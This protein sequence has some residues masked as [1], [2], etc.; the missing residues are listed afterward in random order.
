L[1]SQLAN[2]MIEKH[3]SSRSYTELQNNATQMQRFNQIP[4]HN[5]RASYDEMQSDEQSRNQIECRTN[6]L[7][8]L[9]NDQ[10]QRLDTLN[11]EPICY[12][13]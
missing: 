11:Q 2:Q 5:A 9:P 6:N 1:A 7:Q 3:F 12:K 4:V 8:S 10:N 13:D